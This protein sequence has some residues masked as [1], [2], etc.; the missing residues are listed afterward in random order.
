MSTDKPTTDLM[1]IVKPD[2]VAAA[3]EQ[4]WLGSR[5]SYIAA[6]CSNNQ[7][8]LLRCL[9]QL[10]D[11]VVAQS[12]FT[13]GSNG[14]NYS[15]V[16]PA[17]RL[18]MGTLV[19]SAIVAA[20][21]AVKRLLFLRRRGVA[22]NVREIVI[23]ATTTGMFGESYVGFDA[24]MTRYGVSQPWHDFAVTLVSTVGCYIP[25]GIDRGIKW[26]L[27]RHREGYA[28]I[29]ST[30]SGEEH[31]EQSDDLQEWQSIPFFIKGVSYTIAITVLMLVFSPNEPPH[32]FSRDFPSAMRAWGYSELLSSVVFVIAL[33]LA[34]SGWFTWRSKQPLTSDSNV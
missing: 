29:T 28:N 8:L 31:S 5:I 11:Q 19:A 17:A 14:V 22:T 34:R 20:Y 24:L 21:Q 10:I 13:Y 33:C 12:A 23:A 27:Q 32:R 9:E 15:R 3:N 16:R 7:P 18:Y 1:K 25:M 2:V 6:T 4:S 30:A 26:G